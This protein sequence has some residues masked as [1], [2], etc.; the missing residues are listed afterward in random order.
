MIDMLPFEGKK[1]VRYLIL[2]IIYPP[3]LPTPSTHFEQEPEIEFCKAPVMKLP[4][5]KN[6]LGDGTCFF[7]F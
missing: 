3:P 6:L 7:A 2:D 5:K 4:I 1:R